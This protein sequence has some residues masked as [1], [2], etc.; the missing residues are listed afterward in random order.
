[1]SA[2]AQAVFAPGTGAAPPALTGRER[3]QAVLSRCLMRLANGGTSPHDVVLIGPRGN[4]KTALLRWFQRECEAASVDV[5]RL[6]PSRVRTEQ[7]LVGVLLPATRWRKL[8]PA[9]WGVAGIG[10]VEWEASQPGGEA[11]LERLIRR[12]RKRPVALLIDEA[13]TLDTGLGQIL[14]NLSQ[15]VRAQAPF[16]LVLAGTPGLPAHLAAMN[17]SFWDRLGQGLLG[18]GRLSEEAARE[19]LAKPLAAHDVGIDDDALAVAVE[20]SQRY[21]YFVQLWGESLWEQRLASAA[22]QLTLDHVAAARPGVVASV[23]T[24][25][26]SRFRELEADKL[27]PAAA[28]LAPLFRTTLDAKATDR[29]VDNAFAAAHIPASGRLAAREGLNRLG[30]I[31]CPPGQLP[32][33]AW[34]AGIPSLTTYVMEQSEAVS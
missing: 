9:K 30:Y 23:S 1:M 18:I 29:D 27:V 21:P 22:E 31:W 2:T 12:C 33:I 4:G 10:K 20:H 26:Q 14:L 6:S 15:D 34:T 8:L 11:V 16:L 25:Y 17:A 19:A 5:A 24:Y 3:E 28:A 32:P 13:H 7:E